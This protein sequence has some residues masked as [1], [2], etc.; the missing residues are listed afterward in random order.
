MIQ[1]KIK[2]LGE[3]GLSE[4]NF[5]ET[6]ESTNYYPK[7]IDLKEYLWSMGEAE[8]ALTCVHLDWHR[9]SYTCSAFNAADQIVQHLS[10]SMSW[11]GLSTEIPSLLLARRP[12]SIH[13]IYMSLSMYEIH[14]YIM[15]GMICAHMCTV[16]G[17]C[18]LILL[19]VLHDSVDA[20]AVLFCFLSQIQS[21]RRSMTFSRRPSLRAEMML[22]M[23]CFWR[24]LMLAVSLTLA[25]PCKTEK[26]RHV[27]WVPKK[28]GVLRKCKLGQQKKW[29]LRDFFFN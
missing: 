17:E 2:V 12:V 28:S 8:W 7:V 5:S 9:W 4:T 1:E 22:M 26:Q 21:R 15:Y 16:W 6:A 24:Q 13:V 29:Q 25:V 3:A 19:A 23:F 20:D 14:T 18:P 27:Q 11:L 10:G